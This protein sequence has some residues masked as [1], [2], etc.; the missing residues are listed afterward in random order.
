M[1]NL[2]PNHGTPTINSDFGFFI[3]MGIFAIS[4]GYFSTSCLVAGIALDSLEGEHEK[5][6]SFAASSATLQMLIRFWQLAGTVLT[7]YLT[8]GLAVGSLLSFAIRGV[9]CS[10]NPF[11]G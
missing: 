3:I 5:V 6:V 8:V 7:F 4:N 10:C 1:C 11:T 2:Q 9:V